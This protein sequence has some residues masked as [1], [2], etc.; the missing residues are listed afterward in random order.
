MPTS[1]SP[2]TNKSE[3]EPIHH[4]QINCYSFRRKDGLWDIEG[5]LV[6]TKSY[7][8][9]NEY[10]GSIKPGEALHEMWLRITIDNEFIIHDAEAK[11]LASPYEIC[12]SITDN[13][14]KLIGLKIKAGWRRDINKVAG[15]VKGCTHL[16]E[17]L[18]PMATTA[19]QALYPIISTE[20]YNSNIETKPALID[21]CHAYASDSPLV[22]T[23]WPKYYIK[24]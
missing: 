15:G 2:F 13:Y 12:P 20:H 10:R 9:Q 21:S 18:S 22:K 24:K 5:H 19:F 17:L 8:F 1:N 14:K 7:I 16:V 4:R 6:D 11:T 23:I 3:R